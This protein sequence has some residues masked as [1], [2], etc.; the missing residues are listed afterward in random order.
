MSKEINDAPKPVFQLPEERWEYILA[1]LHQNQKVISTELSAELG[2]SDDTIRRDLHRLAE[3]GL[4]K[5]VHGGAIPR[6]AHPLEYRDRLQYAVAEKQVLAKKA[7]KLFQNGQIL[8]IDGGTTNMELVR[9]MPDMLEVTVFTNSLPIALE[10]SAHPQAEVIFLGGKIFKSSQ[11]AV[12]PEVIKS[13]ESFRADWCLLGVCSIHPELG[14]SVPDRE[15]ALVKQKMVE[16]ALH[17]VALATHDKLN[18]A[19]HYRV[20]AYNQLDYLLTDD[21]ADDDLLM[22]Y[23]G[24]GVEIC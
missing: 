2:V 18:T 6:S 24:K 16:T 1:K 8:L 5:K 23:R 13:L 10:L 9:Q 12:G 11:V 20:C 17:T 14:L 3:D 19:D 15:E 22:P 4:I 21:R 7:Q